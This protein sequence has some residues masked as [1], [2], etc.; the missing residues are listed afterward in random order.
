MSTAN[1]IFSQALALPVAERAALAHQL[2]ESLEPEDPDADEAWTKEIQAR[3]DAL[4]RGELPLCDW[5]QA[6][7][8]VRAQLPRR[9]SQ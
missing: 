5:E 1:D 3:S 8:E 6:I 4:H 7:E 2:L 9:R